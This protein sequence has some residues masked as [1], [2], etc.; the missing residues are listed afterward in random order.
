MINHRPNL[1]LLE[2]VENIVIATLY[3]KYTMGMSFLEIAE[4][5]VQRVESYISA[6]IGFMEHFTSPV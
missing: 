6:T 4:N 2:L 3:I 5:E 1:E